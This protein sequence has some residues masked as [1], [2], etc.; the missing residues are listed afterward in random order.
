MFNSKALKT[1]SATAA[2]MFGAALSA[3]A[4]A[5]LL[6]FSGSIC[7]ADGNQTCGSGLEIGQNYGDDATVDV[8][9]R[10]IAPGG[11]TYEPF[12]KY[13][14]ANYGDL[15]GIVWGGANSAYASEITFTAKAGYEISLTGFDAGCYLNRA[16][17]QA[18]PFS[19]TS[20]SGTTIASST[21]TPP[22]S[23]HDTI[24][25]NSAFFS[26]G[27]VL[28][29]GPDGY[30]GGLDNIAFVTRSLSAGAVPET[31][32]WAMAII[33]FGMIGAAARRRRT[34]VALA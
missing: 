24:A 33:G 18:I 6:D 2:L 19:V 12:L 21:A 1:L 7:G 13:W 23:G 32:T 15:V 16:S 34:D 29:W 30:D 27:I 3:P 8:S 17:C 11:A 14:E 26:D 10:S 5:G 31:G 25:I 20:L 4:M 22:P 9:Y 28:R